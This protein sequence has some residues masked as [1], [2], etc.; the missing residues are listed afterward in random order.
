MRELLIEKNAILKPN[1]SLGVLQLQNRL[2]ALR[3]VE[4][5]ARYGDYM[6]TIPTQFPLGPRNPRLPGYRKGTEISQDLAIEDKRIANGRGEEGIGTLSA[7]KRNSL[8]ICNL[9]ALKMSDKILALANALYRDFMNVDMVFPP[10]LKDS[11]KKFLSGSILEEI[12]F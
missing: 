10:S 7:C 11:D 3:G 2:L 1:Q 8:F 4:Y 9:D 12:K 6:K 5:F